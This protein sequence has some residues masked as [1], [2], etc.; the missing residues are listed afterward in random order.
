MIDNKGYNKVIMGILS[1]IDD[2][3]YNMLII[4]RAP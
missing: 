2:N 3:G 4:A 1:L